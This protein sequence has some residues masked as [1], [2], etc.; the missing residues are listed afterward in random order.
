M[1]EIGIKKNLKGS[2]FQ[3]RLYFMFL[4]DGGHSYKFAFFNLPFNQIT[5]KYKVYQQI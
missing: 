3:K 4:K 5:L 2:F 1:C